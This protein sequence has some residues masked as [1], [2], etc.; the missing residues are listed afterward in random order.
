MNYRDFLY[1]LDLDPLL[2]HMICNGILQVQSLAGP[3]GMGTHSLTLP[4]TFPDSLCRA[5]VLGSLGIQRWKW[6]NSWCWGVHGLLTEIGL[7]NSCYCVEDE[8]SAGIIGA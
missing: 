4:T 7:D 3:R 1:I 6:Y 5:L 8:A 2:R